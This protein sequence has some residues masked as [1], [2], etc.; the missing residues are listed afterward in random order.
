MLL[1][2]ATLLKMSINASFASLGV[3]FLRL[4]IKKAPRRIV[5]VLWGVVALRLLFPFSFESDVS[6]VP[7]VGEGVYEHISQGALFSGEAEG[8]FWET[9]QSGSLE[10][11]AESNLLHFSKYV[12]PAVYFA[13]SGVMLCTMG[14]SYLRLRKKTALSVPHAKGVRFCDA[15]DSPFVLGFLHP[16]IYIPFSLDQKC[17]PSILAHERAHIRRNDHLAKPF[18]FLLLSLHWFNPLMWFCFALFCRDLETACDEHVLKK[19]D[20]KMRQDYAR[21]LLMCSTRTESVYSCPLAFGELNVKGRIKMTLSYKK[22]ILITVILAVILALTCSLLLL[23]DPKSQNVVTDKDIPATTAQ[24]GEE[25]PWWG[26]FSALSLASGMNDFV[27][28]YDTKALVDR[29]INRND[30][31]WSDPVI[32]VESFNQL[33]DLLDA[34]TKDKKLSEISKDAIKVYFDEKSK[35]FSELFPAA[36]APD[37]FEDHTLLIFYARYNPAGIISE[38][39]LKENNGVL[40]VVLTIDDAPISY[41]HFEGDGRLKFYWIAKD[42]YHQ[43]KD[44]KIQFSTYLTPESDWV[45]DDSYL[46]KECPENKK[47]YINVSRDRYHYGDQLSISLYFG[48]GYA[49]AEKTYYYFGYENGDQITIEKIHRIVVDEEENVTY[50]PEAKHVFRVVDGNLVYDETASPQRIAGLPDGAVFTLTEL[51]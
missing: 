15:I 1:F 17:I 44:G 33:T 19:M 21:A 2:F 8:S 32:A 26:D 23:A 16:T 14:I 31:V 39:N 13:G 25:R 6:I 10:E 5:C 11:N 22:P 47:Y 9:D 43:Y 35:E 36:Q 27:F 29:A 4:L 46:W 48:E 51:K 7:P 45:R 49:D 3:I 34:C 28:T 42:V 37:F 40:N 18:G 30:K 20:P 12:I 38:I 24:N 50:I 41:S